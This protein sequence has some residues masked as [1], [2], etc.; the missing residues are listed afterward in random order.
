[1]AGKFA[2]LTSARLI[3]IARD[4]TGQIITRISSPCDPL[5]A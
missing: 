5:Y 3:V 4:L 1:M 2:D